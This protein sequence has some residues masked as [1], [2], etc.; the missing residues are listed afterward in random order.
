MQ[1]SILLTMKKI[2]VPTDFS[3][4][5]ERAIDYAVRIAK[6][7][8][9]TI[10]I[11]HACDHLY[12][13]DM[14]NVMAKGDYNKR[15]TEEAFSNLEILQKS[16]EETEQVIVNIQLYNGSVTDTITVAAEE[17][18]VD[19]IIMGTLGIS[20]LRDKILGSKT[21]AVIS[22]S[23]V[24]VLAIPLEY[25]WSTPSKFLLAINHFDEVT[26]I[27]SPA[28]DMAMVFNAALR[29][30]VFTDQDNAGAA[31]FVSAAKEINFAE[32]KLRRK[33][34]GLEINAEHLSGRHFEESINDY[35]GSNKI[36]MLVMTTHKRSFIGNIFNRSLTCRMSY[37]AKVPILAIPVV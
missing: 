8:Q 26:D 18:Q 10:Y 4:N 37:H 27:L 14:N 15:M 32:E 13:P 2:L 34:K 21:A 16:I 5:A 24:P 30:V 36:D 7:S 22:N 35:I 20:G 31:G 17:H 1:L 25:E 3:L 12:P 33:Y 9:A 28:F 29:L 6:L 11:I 23:T 19:L